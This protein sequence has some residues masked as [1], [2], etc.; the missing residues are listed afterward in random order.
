MTRFLLA[1][2]LLVMLVP[3]AVHADE[4]D[5]AAA[6]KALDDHRLVR[7]LRFALARARQGVK[8]TKTIGVYLG[9][10]VFPPS[11]LAAVRR[12]DEAD[13]PPRLLFEDD[14][15]TQGLR[16]LKRLGMPGGWAPSLLAGLGAEGQKALVAF[17]K[18]GG[19]YLGICAGAY[20][21]CRSVVWEG[22]T[23]PYP[24]GLVDGTATGPVP[25]R[26]PW[27]KAEVFD[28][29][30]EKGRKHRTIYAGG[31]SFDVKDATV[32]ARYPNGDAAAVEV[33]RGRGRLLLTGAHVEFDGRKDQDLL[34]E[35]GW[36][37]GL[38]PGDAAVW[39][40]FLDRLD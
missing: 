27:P 2:V 37:R 7:T 3:A 32:L 31:G 9:R 12:L 1:S 26:A 11:G 28:L 10:G 6:Q 14:M 17:V 21:P 23:W 29:E 22:Q 13:T 40:T 33:K 8:E 35:D 20:L 18:G 19:R 30:L 16:G 24:T 38:R 34:A 39:A 15:T 25:G 36:A 4:G 5:A